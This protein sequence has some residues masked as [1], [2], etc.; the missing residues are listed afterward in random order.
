MC[1]WDK[2]K[3]PSQDCIDSIIYDEYLIH[4]VRG[5]VYRLEGLLHLI[6]IDFELEPPI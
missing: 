5:L 1:I 3:A 6:L 4:Y 2:T